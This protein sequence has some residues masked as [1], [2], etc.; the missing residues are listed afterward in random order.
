MFS[1]RILAVLSL[2]AASVSA[3]DLRFF[4]QNNCGRNYWVSCNS[5]NPGY[6]CF[7]TNEDYTISAGLFAIPRDWSLVCQWWDQTG[8]SSGQLKATNLNY[9]ADYVCKGTP[10]SG[11]HWVHGL[12]YQF[13]GRKR[14]LKADPT[15][16][17]QRANTL[18]LDDGSEYDLTNMSNATYSEVVSG[19]FITSRS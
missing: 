18:H 3:I 9:G 10:V 8:C 1:Q 15:E 13:N 2:A 5:A 17:C 12:S 14:E 7:T 19:W 16:G 11:Q 6:C 4:N